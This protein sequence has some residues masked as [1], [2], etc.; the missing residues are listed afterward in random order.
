MAIPLSALL[1]AD[2]DPGQPVSI[3]LCAELRGGGECG[4]TQAA[5][6][7]DEEVCSNN[8]FISG[9]A[10]RTKLNGAATTYCTKT[11]NGETVCNDST[12]QAIACG[13]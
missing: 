7:D 2:S 3:A 5:D 10:N 6:C 9:P 4:G 13:L 1:S 11:Y 8:G 12:Q